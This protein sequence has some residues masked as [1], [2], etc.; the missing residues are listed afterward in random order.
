MLKF[1][2][3]LIANFSGFKTK[4]YFQGVAGS[5][6]APEVNFNFGTQPAPAPTGTR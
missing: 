2:G 5:Q 6:N 4:A 1:P 3:N